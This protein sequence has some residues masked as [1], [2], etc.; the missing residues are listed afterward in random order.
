MDKKPTYEE[1]VNR[2]KE[3]ER[4]AV[5]CQLIE[6]ELQENKRML[7]AMLNSLP[8]DVFALDSTNR[9]F[10]QISICN[11]NLWNMI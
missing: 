4:E 8:V 1:L 6:E 2:I 7:N 5:E 11:K 10:F 9:Y 3:L